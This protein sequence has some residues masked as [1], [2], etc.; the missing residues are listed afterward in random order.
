MVVLL[1]RS[2]RKENV[3]AQTHQDTLARL[4]ATYGKHILCRR[5]LWA[6]GFDMGVTGGMVGSAVEV[7]GTIISSRTTGLGMST[8]S[9]PI[10]MGG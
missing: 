2:P 8:A 6:R 9:I 5:T 3:Y 10:F 1:C 4:A 7:L